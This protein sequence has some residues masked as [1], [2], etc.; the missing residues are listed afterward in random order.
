MT[1][2]VAYVVA[3]ILILAQSGPVSAAPPSS[4]Q[5]A[6]ASA[7]IEFSVP[8]N[9]LLGVSY[10]VSRWETDTRP[11][12]AGGYGP[13]Q[14]LDASSA[15]ALDGKGADGKAATPA[16]VAGPRGIAAASA[17]SGVSAAEIKTS[18]TQNIRAGAA[19]LASYARD[20]IGA[21][22]ADP[23]KWYGAVAKYSS[24]DEASV[25]LGFA[26]DVFAVMKKG[27]AR[28]TSSGENVTLAAT[29]TSPDTSTAGSLAL[30]DRKHTSFDCPKTVQCRFIPAAYHQNS[31]D[32]GDYGNFDLARRESD[33]LAVRFVV[34]HDAETDYQ[35]T[36]KI[37]QDSLNYVS[38]HYVVRSSDGQI[39]QMVDTK[40]VAWHAGNWNVNMHA[41]GYEHEGF[42]IQGTT[43]YTEAM[44]QASAALTTHLAA[45]YGIPLDRAHIIG[46]DDIPGPTTGFVRG[47]HWDPGPFWN[48]A[49][50]MALLGAPITA[51]ATSGN[52][53][54]IAP[55]FATNMPRVRDC[56]GSGALQAAQPANFVY[57]YTSPTG[58][59]ALLFNDP[60][61]ASS[62]HT[63]GTDC[64]ADWGDKADTGQTFYRVQRQGDWDQLYYAGNTVWF[65]DPGETK[66][67]H[68]TATL[69]TPKAGATSIPVY[70]RAYPESISTTTLTMYSIPAGQKYV[71]YEKVKG[72]Y[73]E[74]TTFNNLDS[75][76]LHTTASDF[77]MIQFNHRLAFVKASDVD[78][79][80]P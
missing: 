71:A 22:P 62:T 74:A 39:T 76:V 46:H 50:Y 19:L 49:R 5:S 64:A 78:V 72:D 18:A 23:G 33:S 53:V 60:G 48:W 6:F 11:S 38:A 32:P 12:A 54:T 1:K 47:M 67:A 43:W 37:F 51:T 70:G 20:T 77:Y 45:E 69:V 16:L 79:S 68:T 24:S 66:I 14:L 3:A 55:D 56:E 31:K 7:A 29:K 10:V 30:L 15:P 44:Y 42:A 40:N 17:V 75:Y 58:D 9:V 4:L 25:A 36:I 41:I 80:A 63:K 28:T 34:I 2:R 21:T 8:Q 52:V 57:L 61:L 27:A 35:T 26:D 59:P 65:Y 73:Y 13:M